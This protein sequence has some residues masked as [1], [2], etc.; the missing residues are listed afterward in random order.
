MIT[1]LG[2]RHIRSFHLFRTSFTFKCAL[3]SPGSRS[4]AAEYAF[5]FFDRMGSIDLLNSSSSIITLV[6]S[7]SF[8]RPMLWDRRRCA[9]RCALRTAR[10]TQRHPAPHGRLRRVGPRTQQVQN[11]FNSLVARDTLMSWY[12][13]SPGFDAS[14]LQPSATWW[15]LTST[16]E[17]AGLFPLHTNETELSKVV[18]Y[19]GDIPFVT[20][21]VVSEKEHFF[22]WI[23]A[24]IRPQGL[25]FE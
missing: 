16:S 6:C 9:A 1:Q 24:E 19:E 21:A 23:I 2:R 25:I 10:R 20:Q 5:S 11:R 8:S 15:S 4:G 14:W 3:M 12:Q 7:F 18:S 22:C 13:E 17:P